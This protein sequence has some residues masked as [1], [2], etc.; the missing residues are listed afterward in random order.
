MIIALDSPGEYTNVIDLKVCIVIVRGRLNQI[1]ARSGARLSE[2]CGITC[3]TAAD[4]DIL[5]GQG[6]SSLVE[7]CAVKGLTN[8]R[9]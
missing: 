1:C 3:V 8:V 5:Q 9:V 2:D 7:M 6:Y 4:G